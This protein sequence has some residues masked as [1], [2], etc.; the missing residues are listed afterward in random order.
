M[1]EQEAEETTDVTVSF[2]NEA[3]SSQRGTGIDGEKSEK[4]EEAALSFLSLSL[5]L[6]SMWHNT[7]LLFDTLHR[8][9]HDNQ[10]ICCQYYIPYPL[11]EENG[12][13]LYLLLLGIDTE[14]QP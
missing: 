9:D 2:S 13:I 5:L 3:E 11:Q 1:T 6:N 14:T 12:Y 8:P 4:E 10:C 7:H